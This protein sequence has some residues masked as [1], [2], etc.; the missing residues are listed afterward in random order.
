MNTPP[1]KLPRLIILL[2][3]LGLASLLGGCGLFSSGPNVIHVG[4]GLQW[5]TNQLG[6]PDAAGQADAASVPSARLTDPT[7]ATG[8]GG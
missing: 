3:G 2:A 6:R 4:S 7:P 5:D 8:Q 1:A